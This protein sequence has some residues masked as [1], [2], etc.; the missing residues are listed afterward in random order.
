M[1]QYGILLRHY[2]HASE[3]KYEARILMNGTN[4]IQQSSGRAFVLVLGFPVVPK[5]LLSVRSHKAAAATCTT[6]ENESI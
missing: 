5:A 6:K 2:S 1:N 3:I 4:G